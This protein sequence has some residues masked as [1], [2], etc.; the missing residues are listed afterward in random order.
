MSH[1]N[2]QMISFFLTTECN[3]RCVYCYNQKERKKCD[4]E[5]LSLEFAKKGLDDFFKNSPS[6]HIRFYGPGEPTQEIDLM[7]EITDYA[8]EIAGDE[9]VVELQT[10]GAFGEKA[11]E[12]VA[13]N[14]D[15]VWVS[16]D[17]P[18]DI[19]NE[20]RPFPQNKPSSGV[21]E[22]N[23]KY[24]LNNKKK[25]NSMVG[26]RITISDKNIYRQKEMIDYFY[27]LGITYMW[28]DPLFPEVADIPVCQDVVRREEKLIDMDLYA[29]K[30]IEAYKYAKEKKVFYG[31]FLACNFDGVSPYHCRACTPVPHLTTDGY[32]SACDMVTFGANAHHMDVFVIGKWDSVN[33]RI[34]YYPE[35]MKKLQGRRSDNMP[36]CLNCEVA[37]RCGGYC[38]GEV[39]N[40]TG[41]LVG[42]KPNNC[43]AIRKIAREIGVLDKPY[44]Y[45]H[46]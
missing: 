35:K 16:F 2:K 21:I 25:E 1:V 8:Y 46:P 17:G 14:V 39:V 19:Q 28:T 6:R 27:D 38:L 24:L 43:K 33:K 45:L 36:H 40:E 13:K 37:D 26:A 11:R 44:P 7:K 41:T 12:W 20:N 3:L 23:V 15:I 32:V 31:S 34:I 4:V 9:L 30:F 22:S 18:P 42:Q 10:N 5:K 29:Q